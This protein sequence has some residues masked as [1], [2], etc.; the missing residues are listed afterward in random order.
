MSRLAPSLWSFLL[1]LLAA[2][3]GV[4]AAG[5][6]EDVELDEVLIVGQQ[7]QIDEMRKEIVQLEDRFHERYNELNTND[8]FDIHCIVEARTGTRMLKR[9]CRAIYMERAIEQEGKEAFEIR[10]SIQ[11]GAPAGSA[12]GPPAPASVAINM[13]LPDF[14]KNMRD[15]AGKDR[16]LTELLRRRAELVERFMAAR[17]A[18]LKPEPAKR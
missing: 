14:R 7:A 9:S 1:L 4:F 5:P 13:R 11:G 17:R 3:Q 8:D 12:S 2:V 10:Q 6:P 16:E 15:I 18:I